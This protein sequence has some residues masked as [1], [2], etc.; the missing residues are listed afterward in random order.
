M[1]I[2]LDAKLIAAIESYVKSFP[3]GSLA[4]I[5]RA[6]QQELRRLAESGLLSLGDDKDLAGESL[7]IRVLLLLSAIG[8]SVTRGRPGMEDLVATPP[9]G[10]QPDLPLVIEVKSDRKPSL[11]REDL[12]QLDDWVFDLSQEE[13]A[14]KSGLGGRGDA[15]AMATLGLL[16]SIRH[17]PTPHKGV[18][19]FNA[20][21]GIPFDKRAP[22]ALSADQ[23]EFAKKRNFCLVPINALIT[24]TEVVARKDRTLLDVWKELH[25]TCG[26][27]EMRSA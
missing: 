22:I 8:I 14:R 24:L 5:S 15:L 21:V 9:E 10:A 13:I 7:E 19:V 12:R 17:H 23:I 18:L 4:V 26:I 2:Q 1:A 25:H 6:F 20:P 3:G 11:Q 27:L 16:T